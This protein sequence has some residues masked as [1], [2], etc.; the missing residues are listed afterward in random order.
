MIYKPTDD[1]L[2]K[3]KD[4]KDYVLMSTAPL[5]KDLPIPLYYQ[6]KC[7]LMKAIEA[8]EWQ[9]DQQLPNELQLAEQYG[10]S[11]ITVRQ[12][13]QGLADMGYIRREHGRGTFVCKLKLD[14]GPRELTSFS[15]EIRRHRLTPTSRVVESM[16]QKAEGRVAESLGAGQVFMLKRLRMA[17]GEPM[18]LQTAHIPLN[19]V[20]GLEKENLENVSLYHI[21][22]SRYG[23]YPARARETYFAVKAKPPVARLLGIPSGSPVFDVE[24]ITYQTNGKPFEFVQSYMRGDRYN[25]ILDLLATRVPQAVR[26]DG[27]RQG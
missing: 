15:E 24:R 8:G 23:L 18:G 6:L 7:A 5:S 13:L 11:K 20:P 25:V 19:L 10:I 4:I 2:D 22:Q 21:L 26:E 27:P 12:A 3:Q 17:D 9:P 16:V 1:F 14:Q